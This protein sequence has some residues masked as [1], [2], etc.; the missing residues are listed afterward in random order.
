V[1][2]KVSEMSTDL[3]EFPNQ[4]TREN[5]QAEALLLSDLKS[6]TMHLIAE[7]MGLAEPERYIW[8]LHDR[9]QLPGATC[10]AGMV[11]LITKRNFE[12]V[13][14]NPEAY[15]PSSYV[16]GTLY[17]YYILEVCQSP[18]GPPLAEAIEFQVDPLDY[19][20]SAVAGFVDPT[21]TQNSGLPYPGK[22]YT[23]LTRDDVM[24]LRHLMST[25][26]VNWESPPATALAYV[27]NTT[28]ELVF[29]SN[30]T[31]FASLALTNPPGVLQ[32]LYPNL[33]ILSASNFLANVWVTNV[34]AVFT[35]SP[36][37]PIGV[38]NRVVFVTTPTLVAQ[39]Q[40]F[41]TFGNLFQVVYTNGAWSAIPTEDISSCWAG[42]YPACRQLTFLYRRILSRPQPPS[43]KLP[44]SPQNR[45]RP[46]RSLV[47]FSF[48][49]MPA[50]LPCLHLSPL[51]SRRLPTS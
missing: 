12:Q 37:D 38:S 14:G 24:G 2:P 48:C 9:F 13:P 45:L 51:S 3:T 44:T 43:C 20:F 21:L 42:R 18:P 17:S 6:Y 7:Q 33:V 46:T 5:Y 23:G 10:P 15:E 19:V 22:F 47:S 11:Y 29:T 40:W 8:T 27:T 36:Y 35:S 34:I 39:S 16:N 31:E 49:P 32:T 28:P 41:Y 50:T 25:N 4:A 26:N 30:L 1:L